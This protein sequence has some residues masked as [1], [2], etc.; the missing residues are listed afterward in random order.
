MPSRRPA[1][2]TMGPPDDPRLRGAVCS[3]LPATRRPRGPRNACP[4]AETNPDVARRPRQA[5]GGRAA[6]GRDGGR[7]P[8]EGGHAGGVDGEDSNVTVAVDA[9]HRAH[10]GAPV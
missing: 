4:T 5:G 10:R 8:G 1:A 6:L 2:S 9:A 3:M 7:I